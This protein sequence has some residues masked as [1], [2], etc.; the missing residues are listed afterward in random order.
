MAPVNGVFTVLWMP[1]HST[2]PGLLWVLTVHF[3]FEKTFCT[4][5]LRGCNMDLRKEVFSS[6][7]KC[8]GTLERTMS[9]KPCTTDSPK[10]K[11]LLTSA[12]LWGLL[13]IRNNS[14]IKT[15]FGTK[16]KP[17]SLSVRTAL[18]GPRPKSCMPKCCKSPGRFPDQKLRKSQQ[19]GFTW[20]N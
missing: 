8:P 16:T 7:S 3:S 19:T 2:W 5:P 13:K 10:S 14:G 6:S 17:P 4:L 18:Y 15:C 11:V 9:T 20:R 1:R 12:Y